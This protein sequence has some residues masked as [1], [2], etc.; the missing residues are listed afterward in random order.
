MT[1]H[2]KGR[3][4]KGVPEMHVHIRAGFHETGWAGR[5]QEIICK[6]MER[7]I[8]TSLDTLFF[9]KGEAPATLHTNFYIYNV[10]LMTWQW[11]VGYFSSLTA[12]FPSHVPRPIE[13]KTTTR[14]LPPRPV[15]TIPSPQSKRENDKNNSKFIFSSGCCCHLLLMG[16]EIPGISLS[17]D[18]IRNAKGNSG[19]RM[20]EM[21]RAKTRGGLYGSL[22]S[23]KR[24]NRGR[25]REDCDSL[26]RWERWEEPGHQKRCRMKEEYNI[27]FPVHKRGRT[28]WI[29][30]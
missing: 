13:N 17:R 22:V 18:V 3:R 10:T 12:A 11:I 30:F 1:G 15:S 24:K 4:E 16:K 25:R 19:N 28:P 8:I 5:P 2:K 29:H 26:P 23:I 14:N 9:L 7:H 21:C 6:V 20:I 27:T